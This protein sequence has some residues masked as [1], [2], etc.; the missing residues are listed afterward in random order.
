MILVSRRLTLR[1]FRTS[2]AQALAAY[3]SD[4]DVARYQ[5][6]EPP[7]SVV[8]ATRFVEE[9]K[10]ADENASGWYQYAIDVAD[11]LIGDIGVN[12]HENRKQ[13]E[14][15]YT[16]AAEHQ[17]RGYATEAL[18]RMLDNLFADRGLH[19]V[20]A[21]CDARNVRSARLL[22]RLGFRQEGH[23][24]EHTWTKGE[25]TDDLLFGLLAR[26]YFT[27]ADSL[28]EAETP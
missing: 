21:E 12:L 16:L 6:W 13:A 27:E 28:R 3:R 14:I 11:Q 9:L 25:W 2:D 20:S 1:P 8:D 26:D 17:G 23:R 15:G 24:V 5:G 18:E 10:F 4:P 22:E 19:R 7:F